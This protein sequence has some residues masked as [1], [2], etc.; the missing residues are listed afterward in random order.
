MEVQLYVIE[1]CIRLKRDATKTYRILWGGPRKS[2]TSPVLD[3]Q[4]R[5]GREACV[6]SLAFRPSFG[7]PINRWHPPK[8]W[9]CMVSDRIFTNAK[10]LWEACAEKSPVLGV[11][12]RLDETPSRR[13]IQP[14]GLHRC[15]LLVSEQDPS[16]PP[17]PEVA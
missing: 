14:Y 8:H 17:V 7:H 4:Q 16:G 10:D 5:Q 3:A 6:Q 15:R 11:T 12:S 13:Y 2:S 1:F 9:W